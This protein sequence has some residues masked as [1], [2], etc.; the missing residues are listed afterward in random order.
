MTASADPHVDE[1]R[2]FNRFY[3][4]LIGVLDEGH[5]ASPFSLAQV[6][7]LYELAHQATPTASELCDQLALDPGYLSR[8]LRELERRGLVTR[9]RSASDRRQQ[10]LELT[11]KGRRTVAELERKAEAAVAAVLARVP[12]AA[13]HELVGA[14]RRIRSVLEP[15]AD[16][17]EPFILRSHQPGDMGWIV[18]RH[19]VLYAQEYGWDERFEALVAQITAD[20][21]TKLDPR[22]ERCWIAERDGAIVGAV[23]LVARSKTTAQLRLLYVEPSARGLGLG[24]RLVQECTRF[25]RQARYRKIALWTNSV[26]VSARKIY[27]AEG[28]RLVEETKHADFGPELVGQTWEL[29]LGSDTS[30]PAARTARAP[31]GG[32]GV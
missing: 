14:M 27:E 28:Y 11:A 12:P 1:M 31:S 15:G 18:H 26:L 6:R 20:F 7:V 23:F 10:Q 19:G 5:L 17:A 24:R 13:Q 2:R 4:R 30:S 16:R 22:R 3:T 29:D 8:M 9:R 25:A 21:I 32:A